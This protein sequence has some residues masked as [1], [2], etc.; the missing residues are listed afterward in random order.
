MRI[1]VEDGGTQDRVRKLAVFLADLRSFWPLLVP[2]VTGWWRQQF[3]SEGSFAGESWSPLSP[4]YST[5]KERHYPGAGILVRTGALRRAASNPSRAVT[6][7]SLTLTIDSPYLE[8][9]QQ[10]D[11]DADYTLPRRPLVFG[12][13]LPAAAQAELQAAADTY[14][15]DLLSRI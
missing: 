13:P 3:D 8:Y 5:W 4:Q 9:H 1:V 11:D 7:T 12:D 6:P 15:T 10:D 14:I 2:V